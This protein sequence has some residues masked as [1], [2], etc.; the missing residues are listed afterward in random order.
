MRIKISLDKD[1]IS[2]IRDFADEYIELL[3]SNRKL[4]LSSVS[5]MICI[6]GTFNA[7]EGDDE[8][9]CI[10]VESK[11]FD[12]LSLESFMDIIVLESTIKILYYDN[13]DSFLY[14]V[15][16]E[17]QQGFMEI[18]DK[19]E[20][21]S[22]LDDYESVDL[23]G[24]YGFISLFARLNLPISVCDKI[25]YS[26]SNHSYFFAKFDSP[27]FCCDSKTLKRIYNLNRRITLIDQYIYSKL[28]NVGNHLFLNKLRLNKT[29]D[30]D[31][32]LKSK[33]SSVFEVDMTNLFVVLRRLSVP[34]ESES[35][36]DLNKGIIKIKADGRF[37][38]CNC[39]TT[40]VKSSKSLEKEDVDVSELLNNLKIG[41]KSSI[42]LNDKFSNKF[43]I[44]NLPSWVIRFAISKKLTKFYL[45]PNFVILSV[46]GGKLVITRSD[47]NE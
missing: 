27:D 19:L 37:I 5:G 9:F 17:K 12:K 23:T 3:Y 6:F 33:Y 40:L 28:S 30:L 46:Q 11:I 15:I 38:E 26:Y 34:K 2:E 16:L 4:I 36:I 35:Y 44:L 8:D 20:L 10:R 7:L 25:A 14:N 24:V 32:I 47:L 22:R 45:N 41:K 21:L 39:P 1:K 13:H 43:P 42:D 29:Y 18:K 31:Y